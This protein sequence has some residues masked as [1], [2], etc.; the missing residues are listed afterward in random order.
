MS[1]T[2]RML[3]KKEEYFNIAKVILLEMKEVSHCKHHPDETFYYRTFSFENS[4]IYAIATEKFKVKYPDYKDFTEFHTQIERVLKD[5]ALSQNDC[6][7]CRQIE[8]D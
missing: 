4:Q 3:E 7:I 2:K 6:P 1:I 8:E 5:A